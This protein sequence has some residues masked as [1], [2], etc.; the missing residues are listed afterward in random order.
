MEEKLSCFLFE[1]V[2]FCNIDMQ[3]RVHAR[4]GCTATHTISSKSG[5]QKQAERHPK[6][7]QGNNGGT[8]VWV[9]RGH[10]GIV[11]PYSCSPKH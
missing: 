3:A 2:A 1:S 8:T 7:L 5:N 6:I 4:A 9:G 11:G 10:G